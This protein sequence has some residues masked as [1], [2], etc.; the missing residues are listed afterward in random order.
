MSLPVPPS[1]P[2]SLLPAMSSLTMDS[3]YEM[4]AKLSEAERK[5]EQIKEVNKQ[6]R[7]NNNAIKIPIEIKLTAVLF[8]LS[9][10]YSSILS[11]VKSVDPLVK[12]LASQ[13]I[14]RFFPHFPS[15]ASSALDAMCD[16]CEDQDV[17]TR[18]Q[19]IKVSYDVVYSS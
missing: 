5:P 10:C 4:G 9:S 16:L 12:R 1:I 18:I 17:A 19:A 6:S 15:L 11:G 2:F 8:Q 14:A 3:L 13:F 7:M